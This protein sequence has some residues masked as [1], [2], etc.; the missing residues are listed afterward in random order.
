MNMNSV[1]PG[2]LA[3]AISSAFLMLLM[4]GAAGTVRA[5]A[6][7]SELRAQQA[8][9][10]QKIK[11]AQ[12]AAA[13]RKVTAANAAAEIADLQAEISQV[14]SEISAT[15]SS[16]SDTQSSISSL[17]D[18]I[19]NKQAEYD[20]LTTQVRETL[21]QYMMVQTSR[22]DINYLSI[23]FSANSLSSDVTTKRSYVSIKQKLERLQADLAAAQAD[24]KTQKEQQEQKKSDLEYYVEQNQLQKTQ[25]ARQQATQ[26]ALKASAESAQ[27][28]L[29]K[30]A[31]NARAQ[32]AKI[33]GQI[34]LLS[35]TKAWGNQIVSSND[36]SW[37]YTQTGNDTYLGKSPYT[38]HQ[39]G[40]LITSIAMIS[41]YYGGGTTPDYIARNGSFSSGG[42]L[43]ALPALNISVQSSR[44]VNWSVIND[45]ISNGRPV[46]ISIYLPTVGSVNSDGSSH[47]VVI[48][49]YQ[50]G[51]YLMHDPIGAG[52]GYNLNQVRSMKL[53]R[54]N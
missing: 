39:Y 30:E 9:L 54:K 17:A 34:S 35:A 42:Y 26:A 1:R 37:Y 4:F 20:R 19:T 22:S 11:D 50:N 3:R 23:V 16:I 7:L 25:L 43:L 29:E 48:K 51:Q 13:A 36:W 5:A 10:Q 46:I 32:I 28:A 27:K 41:T 53:V 45:E 44:S 31:A 2:Q 33:E 15:Q 18:Q 24:L 21:R 52:R 38:I 6:T 8:A 14:N 40:C 49:G 12:A 47:F